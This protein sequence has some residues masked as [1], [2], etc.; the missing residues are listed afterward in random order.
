MSFLIRL[1]APK[2]LVW[3][4]GGIAVTAVVTWIWTQGVNFQT[5]QWSAA[6]AR[7]DETTLEAQQRFDA[8][9]A[10]DDTEYRR[11]IQEIGR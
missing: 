4:I 3:L 11:L 6:N 1:F 9:T 10:S 8:R 7:I 2:L 5:R